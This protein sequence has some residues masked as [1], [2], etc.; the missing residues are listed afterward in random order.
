MR[1]L[2]MAAG[3]R[4]RWRFPLAI[5]GV[6]LTGVVLP[7]VRGADASV[8][9]VTRPSLS[10]QAVRTIPA[11]SAAAVHPAPPAPTGDT[12]TVCA[13]TRHSI[14]AL[15]Q[16]SQLVGR[17]I[18]CA[19]VYN[20]AA[21]N[22]AGWESPWFTHQKIPDSNWSRWATSAPGRMLVI[23]Q[24]MRPTVAPSDW[25]YQG[26]QGAYDGYARVLARNL[27]T[28]GLGSSIIRLGFEDNG[29]WM[30]DSLGKTPA[31]WTAWRTYWARIVAAMRQVPG[32]HFEFDW[33]V[34]A[35]Y[36]NIPLAAFYPGDRSVDIIGIDNY[37]SS[38]AHQTYP[39][40]DARW[41][42]LYTQPSGL[43][44]VIAFAKS[45]GKPLSLPEWGLVNAGPKFGV[46]DDPRYVDGIA[47][48][49]RSNV[50]RYQSVFLNTTGDTMLIS[51]AP[52]SLARY[53]A[54]F[55]A[56]GDAVG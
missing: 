16:F 33:T 6:S 43:A 55:G 10:G 32:A 29:T 40:L 52:L 36:R 56:T 15:Q 44:Q 51:Q 4:F 19:L 50:V 26:A 7:A 9:L 35:G 8:N 13:Y 23:S 54:H 20:N 25:V 28:A 5:V 49:V 42:A 34:N 37:D 46:G 31:D 22:W 12:K 53:R 41:S 48:V 47:G 21:S 18:K 30:V 17:D 1:H 11:T 3:R 45:H 14:S 2:S 27:V 39:T 24:D 38:A